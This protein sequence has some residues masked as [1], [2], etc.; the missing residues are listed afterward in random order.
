[1]NI[2][3]FSKA[4]CFLLVLQ[5]FAFSQDLIINTANRKTTSLN[6]AWNYI[7]DPYEMGYFDFR[8][9]AYDKQKNPSNSAYFKNYHAKNKQ[10]LVEYDF[11]KSPKMMIP[12]DWN[13][14]DE[15]LLY[16]EGTVWFK[17]SFDYNLPSKKRLFA[18]FGAVNYK[19]EV[20]L[21]GTKLGVHE[22]GFTPFNFEI[23]SLVKPKDN[24][25]V[26]KVDNK[27]RVDGVPTLNTDWWN[28]GGITREVLLIEEPETFIQDYAIQLKKGDKNKL[29]GYVKLNN[30]NA[31]ENI[32]ISIPEL[33]INQEVASS[34]DFEINAENIKYWSLSTPKLYDV[35]IKTKSQTIKDQIGF[36][37][38]ETSGADILLNGKKVFLKGISIHE[39]NASG[40]RGS[41]EADALRLL[42]WAKEMGCNFVR[43]AHYPHNENMVRLADKMGIL[44]WEEVPVYWTVDF[45][46]ETVLANA[47]NQ[48]SEVI[49]RDNNRASVVI[50]S[51]ANETPISDVRNNFLL[52]LVNHA[53]S[54][55][56]TRLLS[57]AL[58]HRDI[59]GVS[60]IDDKIGEHLDIV[61]VNQYLGWYGGKLE[62]AEKIK[63][64]VPY[65]KP[66]I[67][68]EFGGDAKQ[69]LHGQKN[70]RWT[71]E[72]QEYLYQQNLK[73][74]EKI[75][76]IS[77]LSP[78]ILVD[79]RSPRR[80]LP[81]IQDG[82]N[83]KGLISDKGLKKK[84]FF[85]L[86]DFYKRK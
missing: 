86:R 78:W 50:W 28:Y 57:A 21:N 74:I 31:S 83:R 33:K 18:Y 1:M 3:K 12:N 41:S 29:K 38:I 42:S 76:N 19:A 11:D 80:V 30:S 70:E 20:Y 75:P 60:T 14:Q 81:G 23:T 44:V 48:L 36:R 13:S 46:K 73:M 9:N 58:L 79:F 16:Y 5:I 82:Y 4:I 52:N 61:S 54:L 84:A 26:V 43:L 17:K 59:N 62:D 53:K 65:N 10:E 63:W 25:L 35:F 7:I 6:G 45:T 22:G 68:S 69:G 71:E 56:S 55:D 40:G 49:T 77:G 51:V 72:Y 27:R 85:V 32:T 24:F 8:M 67:V 15:K 2:R 34:S 37:T 64:S 47:K 66:V 39:E